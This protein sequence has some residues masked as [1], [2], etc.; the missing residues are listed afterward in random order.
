M[1]RSEKLEG[2]VLT[3]FGRETFGAL[4]RLANRSEILYNIRAIF[5]F[6]PTSES[7]LPLVSRRTI[8]PPGTAAQPS[9]GESRA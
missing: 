7:L 6:Y 1:D 3:A 5:Q 8:V 9:E 2:L 4:G